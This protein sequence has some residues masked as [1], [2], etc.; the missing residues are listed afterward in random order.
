MQV[1]R[2]LSVFFRTA[3]GPW[4]ANARATQG[5]PAHAH[6]VEGIANLI[7]GEV[8]VDVAD[9]N[10]ATVGRLSALVHLLGGVGRWGQRQAG[11]TTGREGEGRRSS[12]LER[13]SPS[14]SGGWG[15]FGSFFEPL[16]ARA[17]SPRRT[18]DPAPTAS[19]SHWE[20]T[21]ERT[22]C[23]PRKRGRPHG[24]RPPR[25]EARQARRPP[26]QRPPPLRRSATARSRRLRHKRSQLLRRRQSQQSD[27]RRRPR[28]R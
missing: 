5:N 6:I 13:L 28:S 3:R 26:P 16:A 22:Q 20:R 2:K 15:G 23:P 17:D 4:N 27:Q 9:V 24:L 1:F 14:R 8:I 11:A 10:A 21:H 12:R 18:R 25:A 7:L 19:P